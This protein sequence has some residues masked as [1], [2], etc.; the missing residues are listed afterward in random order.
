MDL[1]IYITCILKLQ[2]V[3][4]Y[5]DYLCVPLEDLS[6]ND[7]TSPS[8]LLSTNHESTSNEYVTRDSTTIDDPTTNS[9]RHTLR[10]TKLPTVTT[11]SVNRKTTMKDDPSTLEDIATTETTVA[12]GKT[13]MTSITGQT[14]SD[15]NQQ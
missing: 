7:V 8:S 1:S 14:V 15:E 6:S 2:M 11:K 13:S 3:P 5:S 12:D 10:T 9:N 4:I